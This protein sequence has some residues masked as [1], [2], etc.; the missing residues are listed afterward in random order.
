MSGTGILNNTYLWHLLHNCLAIHTSLFIYILCKLVYIKNNDMPIMKCQLHIFIFFLLLESFRPLGLCLIRHFPAF[1]NSDLML[2]LPH[3]HHPTWQNTGQLCHSKR[4]HT[5][6]SFW[7]KFFRI[8]SSPIS[9]WF[10]NF[11]NSLWMKTL[12][13]NKMEQTICSQCQ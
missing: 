2:Q 1:E 5:R 12:I 8:D 13:S 10:Q 9:S 7:S 4:S 11:D 3:S 6:Q